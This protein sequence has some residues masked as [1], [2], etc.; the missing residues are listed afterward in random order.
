MWEIYTIYSKEEKP[1]IVKRYLSGKSPVDLYAE[2]G[3]SN[4]NIRK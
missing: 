1:K 4:R 3:L 2:I